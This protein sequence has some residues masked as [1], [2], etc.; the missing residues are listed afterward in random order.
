M[1][2]TSSWRTWLVI[3]ILCTAMVAGAFALRPDLAD[4]ARAFFGIEDNPEE[5]AQIEDEPTSKTTKKKKKKPVKRSKT[6]GES[7]EPIEGSADSF[8]DEPFE[9]NVV[10]GDILAE[11][12][13]ATPPSTPE[14]EFV[15]PPEMWQPAGSYAPKASWTAR[16]FDPQAPTEISLQGPEQKPLSESELRSVLTERLLMPCYRDIAQKVPKMS[17]TVRFEGVVGPDGKILHV[18]VVRSQLRSRMVEDCM[19]ETIQKSRFPRSSG[20][21]N[22]RFSMDFRFQ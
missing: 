15:P 21:A 3:L 18:K 10:F 7:E 8:W 19:I 16:G 9:D 12:E 6:T 11:G 2:E 1:R 17:G 14:P 20:E 13:E 4:R 22:T 5:I